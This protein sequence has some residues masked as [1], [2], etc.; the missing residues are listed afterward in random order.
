MC[1]IG[2]SL[3]TTTPD[4]TTI[5]SASGQHR[6]QGNSNWSTPFNIVLNNPQTP[7]ITGIGIYELRVNVTNNVGI[8]SE[9]ALG[10][11]QI[12]ID[13]SGNN[14]SIGLGQPLCRENNCN[15]NSV[16]GVKYTVTVPNANSGHYIDVVNISGTANVTVTQPIA[17][18]QIPE[19]RY[20]EP[21]GFGSVTFDLQLK[22][23]GNN[24][25][26]STRITMTHQSFWNNLPLC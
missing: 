14:Q 19:I 13:C 26:V 11:F 21:N 17:F 10:S 8:T 22:D 24:I 20:V 15:D 6:L 1:V 23:S 9:W 25:I 3:D 12:S 16:C 5:V 4:G 7:N 18:G 2:I